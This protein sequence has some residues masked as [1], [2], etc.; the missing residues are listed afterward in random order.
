MLLRNTDFSSMTKKKI[1]LT[2]IQKYQL[3]L[4]AR[5]NKKIR[6]QY[7]DWIEQKWEVRV[8]KFTISEF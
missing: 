7:I 4:Y 6:S 5:N 3:C 1:T 8:D 2:E